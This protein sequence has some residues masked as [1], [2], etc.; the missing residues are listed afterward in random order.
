MEELAQKIKKENLTETLPVSYIL[1]H[2]E[3]AHYYLKCCS[4]TN[5]VE[6]NRARDYIDECIELVESSPAN[7]PTE[8]Q[9]SV[10]RISA[11]YDKATFN[12]TAF[13]RH[14]ILYLSCLSGESHKKADRA[15]S[16]FLALPELQRL[17]MAHDLS[18]AALLSDDLYNFGELI[19]HSILEALRGSSYEFLLHLITAFNSGR[20][21]VFVSEAA[22]LYQAAKAHPALSAHLEFLQEKLCLMT[23]AQVL[24]VQLKT[25]RRCSFGVI[26]GATNVPLDQVEFLLIRAMSCHIIRGQIDQVAGEVTITWIQPRVLNDS[27]LGELLSALRVWRDRATA[28]IE[29]VQSMKPAILASTT[30]EAI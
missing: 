23:L 4:G 29:V 6:M 9:A 25:S 1:A 16:L 20:L 22:P 30:Y 10:Y 26:S 21:D 3:A 24:F 2:V 8:I 11:L 17:E 7:P 5:E 28:T 27:Q 19:E 14:A 18:I 15:A 12:Y 13:Y